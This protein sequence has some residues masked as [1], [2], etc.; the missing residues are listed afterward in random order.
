[1][2]KV[3]PAPSQTG[4]HRTSW[5]SKDTGNLGHA[6]FFEFV[7]GEDSAKIRAHYNYRLA[8]AIFF[9][10]VERTLHGLVGMVFRKEPKL[11]DDVPEAIRGREATDNRPAVE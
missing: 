9:N 5:D 10:A 4:S 3:G 7:E 1:L 6:H 2:A 8:R 11:G